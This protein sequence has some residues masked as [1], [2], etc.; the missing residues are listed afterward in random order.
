[1]RRCSFIAKAVEVARPAEDV[2]QILRGVGI[3]LIVDGP[4][5]GIKGH[6]LIKHFLMVDMLAE[7]VQTFIS[8]RGVSCMMVMS[9]GVVHFGEE[10]GFIRLRTD[11]LSIS[12][13]LSSELNLEMQ[14]MLLEG[15]A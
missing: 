8:G 1:M 2:E 15:I 13:F 7:E 12:A 10:T 3:R 5:L 14:R 11:A 6:A 9:P 4:V